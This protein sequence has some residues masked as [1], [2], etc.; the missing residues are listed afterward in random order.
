MIPIKAGFS[1]HE[2]NTNTTKKKKT[3]KANKKVT[4]QANTRKVR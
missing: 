1:S 4:A 2:T 3:S